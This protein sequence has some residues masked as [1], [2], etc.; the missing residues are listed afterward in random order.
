MSGFH[1]LRT[2]KIS[3][4]DQLRTVVCNLIDALRGRH[5]LQA[6]RSRGEALAM[7]GLKARGLLLL[8]SLV[9]FALN[10]CSPNPSAFAPA[11]EQ[12]LAQHFF[13]TIDAA[14]AGDGST[15][16][17]LPDGTSIKEGGFV[18]LASIV[19]KAAPRLVGY[20]KEV[21]SRGSRSSLI[22]A[23]DSGPQ[24]GLLTLVFTRKDGR[25]WIGDTSYRALGRPLAEA[26]RFSL[27][28]AGVGRVLLL[29]LPLAALAISIAAIVRVWRSGLFMRRWLWTLGCIPGLSLVSI[30]WPTGRLSWQPL[31]VSLLP[32]GFQRIGPLPDNWQFTATL[33]ILAIIVLLRRRRTLVKPAAAA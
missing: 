15:K 17:V 11:D 21:G 7:S 31:Y 33:P 27:S 30:F 8:V 24:S 16:F 18:G 13:A 29:T 6:N 9:A 3:A 1:P 2:L 5:H 12:R 19:P 23:L 10:A 22:Y 32:A 26:Q 14:R 20:R 28:D 25:P 4:F